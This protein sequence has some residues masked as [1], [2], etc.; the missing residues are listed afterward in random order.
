MSRWLRTVLALFVAL[1]TFGV[2]LGSAQSFPNK[3]VPEI[4]RI[5]EHESG[6]TLVVPHDVPVVP[7]S[8]H[9]GIPPLPAG[10]VTKD[11]GWLELS[12][13]P[14]AAERVAGIIAEAD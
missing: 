13:P 11:L 5:S 3:K 4:G 10:Y 9:G 12:Y 14:S 7:P 6:P 2:T 8:L 1:V